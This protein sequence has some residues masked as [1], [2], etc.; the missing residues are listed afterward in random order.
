MSAEVVLKT[1]VTVV[2]RTPPHLSKCSFIQTLNANAATA[3]CLCHLR[4]ST[5]PITMGIDGRALSYNVTTRFRQRGTTVIQLS[6][7]PC[8]LALCRTSIATSN[9]NCVVLRCTPN[10]ACRP[11]VGSHSLAYTRM[12]SLK[13]GLTKTLNAT[14]HDGVVRRSV[15]PDGVLV[16]KRNLPTLDS[17]NVSA[18]TCSRARAK[19]SPP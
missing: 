15:G 4:A 9:R 6:R 3:I 14:R 12:L 10:N 5:R 2:S 8:V 19:Y 16:A 7:R 13:V 17:F 1:L 18:S 11:L